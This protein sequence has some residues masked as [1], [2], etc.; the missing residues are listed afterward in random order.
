MQEMICAPFEVGYWNDKSVWNDV[1]EQEQLFGDWTAGKYAW[2]L[3][4]VQI[5]DKPIYCRGQQGLWNYE[6]EL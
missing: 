5:L 4:N 2:R 1:S 6:G 3:A